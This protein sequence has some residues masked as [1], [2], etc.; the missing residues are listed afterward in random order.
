MSKSA[1]VAPTILALYRSLSGVVRRDDQL[2]KD[3]RLSLLCEHPIYR[4]LRTL[5]LPVPRNRGILLPHFSNMETDTTPLA[6]DRFQQTSHSDFSFKGLSAQAL[7]I[8]CAVIEAFGNGEKGDDFKVSRHW[9]FRK[10]DLIFS[11]YDWKS[12][13]LYDPALLTPEELW[14]LRTPVLFNVGSEPLNGAEVF[15]F[16]IWLMQ[17][18][19]NKF[20]KSAAKAIR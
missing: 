17:V 15:D 16:T 9:T 4:V 18:T 13:N 10:G 19:L 7:L 11:L 1:R 3:G 8:P 12:T 2:A 6:A 20:E 14:S 5:F